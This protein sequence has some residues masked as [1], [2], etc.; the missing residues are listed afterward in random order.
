MTHMKDR[1]EAGRL[2]Y[3]KDHLMNRQ[4]NPP[5]FK[6]T[7]ARAIER[8]EPRRLLAAIGPD[9]FGYVADAHPFEGINLPVPAGTI[10]S[11]EIAPDLGK[12]TFNFYGHSY[13]GT[14]LQAS[15][16]GLISFEG[17]VPF[18]DTTNLLTSPFARL[19]APL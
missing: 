16:Q 3:G 2:F 4:G 6:M 15:W 12:N 7:I 9:G 8:L 17:D 18:K 5:R 13:T 10:G 1:R 11:V 19:L 14:E